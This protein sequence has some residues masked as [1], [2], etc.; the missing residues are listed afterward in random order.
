[1]EIKYITAKTVEEA[2]MKAS[3]E[4]GNETDVS[5]EIVEMPK[6]GFLG[7][8]STPAKIKVTYETTDTATELSDIVSELKNL[9]LTTDRDYGDYVEPKAQ[10]KPE[11]P[12]QQQKQQSRPEQSQN[13]S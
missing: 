4:Y 12:K 11:Q 7:I 8:G 9:K 6:K 13:R 5:Y 1:M 2:M 3:A 10:P